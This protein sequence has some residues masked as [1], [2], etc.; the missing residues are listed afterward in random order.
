MIVEPFETRRTFIIQLRLA[1]SSVDAITFLLVSHIGRSGRTRTRIE[2]KI[3]GGGP[4]ALPLL[5]RGC[6]TSQWLGP[7]SQKNEL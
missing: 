6:L 5:K 2:V 1:F 7:F 4:R 3:R